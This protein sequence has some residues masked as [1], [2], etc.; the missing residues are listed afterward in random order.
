MKIVRFF[1]ISQQKLRHPHR[2]MPEK[3]S[4]YAQKHAE[5]PVY[6]FG[7]EKILKSGRFL[8]SCKDFVRAKRNL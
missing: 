1:I 8:L 2:A 7:T 5:T 4:G 6:A 3:I